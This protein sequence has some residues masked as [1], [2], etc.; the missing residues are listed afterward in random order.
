MSQKSRRSNAAREN[1]ETN[2]RSYIQTSISPMVSISVVRKNIS[3]ASAASGDKDITS[4]FF[5][6]EAGIR[7][8]RRSLGNAPRQ[9]SLK[10][11]G[12]KGGILRDHK[13]TL[14]GKHLQMKRVATKTG[15]GGGVGVIPSRK[16]E[17]ARFST[18]LAWCRS[19]D[20]LWGLV[21]SHSRIHLPWI[22]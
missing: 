1:L 17:E 20:H 11:A 15:D 8:N 21:L 3:S 18:A 7:G 13:G 12:G 14:G 19:D 16:S 6:L 4:S 22:S 5:A 10:E 9:P 2:N